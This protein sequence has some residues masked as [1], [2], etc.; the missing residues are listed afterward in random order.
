MWPILHLLRDKAIRG[1][2]HD[3]GILK[4]FNL[5]QKKRNDGLIVT[6]MK[7]LCI[8]NVRSAKNA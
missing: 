7:T 1:K 2:N 4:D 3:G 5:Q 6:K 8:R